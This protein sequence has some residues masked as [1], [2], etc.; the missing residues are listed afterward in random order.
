M[1]DWPVEAGLSII[2]EVRIK[3]FFDILMI[4]L[5]ACSSEAARFEFIQLN[6]MR[7]EDISGEESMDSIHPAVLAMFGFIHR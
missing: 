6:L 4:L 5:Y 7:E 1:Q 2:E 3:L